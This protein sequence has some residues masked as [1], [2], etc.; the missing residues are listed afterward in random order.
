MYGGCSCVH[1]GLELGH[2]RLYEQEQTGF[3]D[4]DVQESVSSHTIA[5]DAGTAP[6]LRR[7]RIL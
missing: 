3:T 2:V 1:G 6:G 5:Q 7:E 4:W